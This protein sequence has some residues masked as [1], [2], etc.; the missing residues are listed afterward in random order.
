M[1]S[2][3]PAVGKSTF[4]SHSGIYRMRQGADGAIVAVALRCVEISDTDIGKYS[5]YKIKLEN[6]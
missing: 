3:I 2:K 6:L 5:S 4:R 1:C